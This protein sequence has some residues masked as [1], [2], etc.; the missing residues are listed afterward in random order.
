MKKRIR[1]IITLSLSAALV[2]SMFVGCGKQEEEVQKISS[3]KAV[4]EEEEPVDEHPGETRSP[5]SGEW[6]PDELAAQ[7]PIAVME[8]N[9]KSSLPQYSLTLAD[10]VYEAPMEGKE[11]RYMLVIQDWK[12]LEMLMPIRSCRHYFLFWANGLD[13]IYVHYGQ[14]YIAKDYLEE[15]TVYNLN[16]MDGDLANVTFFRDSS[17][18]APQNAYATGE[19]IQAGIEKRGYS[20]QHKDGFESGFKF[21]EDDENEIELTGEN[22]KAALEVDPGY[23]VGDSYFVYDEASKLY[24]RF[25]FGG[26]T[27]DGTTEEQVAVKN[28]ILQICDCHV[29]EG[30]EK[31]RLDLDNLGSGSGYYITNGMYVPITWEKTDEYAPVHYY[32]E[33]GTEVALNQGQTWICTIE[34]DDAEEGVID[35]TGGE[36]ET[37]SSDDGES[38]EEAE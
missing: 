19:S 31:G 6:I 38:T 17:R 22:A 4:V 12:D 21:N 5:L 16:G 9:N 29:I 20:D 34:A 26:E 18:N 2:I 32:Y 28:I 7:R 14:S 8:S 24:K 37:E 35:I 1:R 36:E 33:D 13:A 25:Q 23:A 11:T 3:A 27:M 10:V 30:D 15:D